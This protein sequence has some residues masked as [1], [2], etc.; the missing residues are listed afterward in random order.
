MLP[1]TPRFSQWSLTFGLPNQNPVNT[2]LLPLRATCL[3]HLNLLTKW[4]VKDKNTV[5]EKAHGP[6]GL[7]HDES[8]Y[9]VWYSCSK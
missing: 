6:I 1:S 3:A 2:S 5:E 8:I 9:I 7:C 4:I